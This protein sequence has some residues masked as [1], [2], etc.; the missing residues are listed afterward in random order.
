MADEA[1]APNWWH[2]LPGV[3][4]ALAAVITAVTGLIVAINKSGPDTKP[5]P[6]VKT[7]AN[8][9][10]HVAP[11][12]LPA[13]APAPAPVSAV[14]LSGVWRD[15]W[16]A[17]TRLVQQGSNFEYVTEGVSCNG[18]YFLSQGA[19]QIA[20]NRVQSAYRSNTPSQGTCTGTISA[21]GSQ[22]SSTCNDSACGSFNSVALRQ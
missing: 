20:G 12:P 3:L 22:I 9:S 7:E 16:N 5:V 18:S 4:T 14:N 11:A 19:G 1:K 10:A 15:N 13:P 17:V 6:E 2:T 21:D 8:S